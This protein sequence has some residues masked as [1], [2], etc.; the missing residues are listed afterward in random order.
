M[1]HPPSI[2]PLILLV[3]AL[4]LVGVAASRISLRAGVPALL[5]FLATG[6][7]AGSDGPGGIWFDNPSA[8][9]SFG[10]VALA[11]LLFG[12]GLDTDPRHLRSVLG[13]GLTLATVGVAISAG[14][15][16]AFGVGVLGLSWAQGLLLGAIVS[17][18]D[19]AAVFSTLR[20]A[21]L[22]LRG[23]I[24]PL[25]ELES[26]SNDPTAIFLT[27]AFTALCLDPV[28]RP[29]PLVGGFILQMGLGLVL[30]VVGG[31]ALIWSINRAKLS[32]EGLYPVLALA[33]AGVLY[34]GST[35]VGGNGYLAIYLAGVLL[36]GAEVVHKTAIVRFM[37]GLAWLMQIGLFVLLGLLVFPSQL[38]DVAGHGLLLTAFAMFVARPLAVLVSLTPFR[39]PLREQAM[40]AWVGLRG[41]VP[42]VLATFPMVAGVPGADRL[43][44]LVFFVVAASVLVQGTTLP[45]VARVLGVAVPVASPGPALTAPSGSALLSL[46]A[47]PGVAGRQVVELG[48][49]RGALIVVVER[50][51]ALIVPPGG[52]VLQPGDALKIMTAQ[53]QEDA[54]H[55]AVDATRP[56]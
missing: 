14:A 20:A 25:L 12:G 21:N 47:G 2:E 54:V 52:T 44:H 24:R 15:V 28:L 40:I 16:G 19:A 4:I 51:G 32:P 42:I 9:W 1:H 26:G 39:V 29:L 45:W 22:G 46:T 41:A 49:P 35:L 37:D 5:L 10:V 48:L 55:A 56:A 18:T 33:M 23:H 30:G 31:K 3:S 7:L 6:M 36:A 43:F 17:S 11:I 38:P 53:G 34:G 8:T 13:P 27:S 50:E